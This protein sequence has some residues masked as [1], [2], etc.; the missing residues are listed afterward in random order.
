MR[1]IVISLGVL[2]CA[3]GVS[4]ATAQ[5][6]RVRITAPK[7]NAVTGP[8]VTVSLEATGVQVVPASG[9]KEDGKGHHH[10]FIDAPLTPA[11]SIIPKTEQIVHLGSG[12]ASYELKGLPP[13][14]HTVIAVFAWG[15]HVPVA[16]MKPDTV[17]FTVRK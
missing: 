8:D 3:A 12:A 6:P 10:L 2:A 5:A 9:L 14:K 1:R 17:T 7:K 13:G 16:G 4:A 15:N 11:D